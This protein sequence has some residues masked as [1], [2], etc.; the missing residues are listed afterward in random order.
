MQQLKYILTV[1]VI[2]IGS[3]ASAQKYQEVKQRLSRP[4]STTNAR[5]NIVEHG[6]AGQAVARINNQTHP[7]KIRGYRVRIFFDNGQ[8]ARAQAN[9]IIERF[10]ESFPEIP[11]TMSYENPYFKVTA[12]NC[13]SSEEAIILWGRV[14]SMFDKAFVIMED[15]DIDSIGINT[16]NDN[17]KPSEEEKSI[18][19]GNNQAKF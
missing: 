10:K 14:K 16:S 15:I 2:F 4:D 19:S 13:L 8:H 7:T 17:N 11:V 3:F 18:I 9:E 6:F 12:G 1:V 5:I